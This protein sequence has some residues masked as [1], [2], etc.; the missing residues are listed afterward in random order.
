MDSERVYSDLLATMRLMKDSVVPPVKVLVR[1]FEPRLKMQNEFRCF[2]CDNRITAISQYN[3]ICA[4]EQLVDE[5]IM[6]RNV[7]LIV[8]TFDKV[9][10]PLRL[11]WPH[12]AFVIDFVV[13]EA[14][15][16]SPLEAKVIELNPFGPMTGSFVRDAS[17]NR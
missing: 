13:L 5:T 7:D 4:Y 10:A 11:Y 1:R 8:D 14:T 9:V 3:D 17:N 15:K 12:C 16:T 6:Q 2:V